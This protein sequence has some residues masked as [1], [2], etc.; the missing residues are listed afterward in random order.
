MR[1]REPWAN[2][3]AQIVRGI[4]AAILVMVVLVAVAIVGVLP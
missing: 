1:G 3:E 2:R 4:V